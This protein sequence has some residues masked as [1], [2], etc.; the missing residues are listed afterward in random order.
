MSIANAAH[1]SMIFKKSG[2]WMDSYVSDAATHWLDGVHNVNTNEPHNPSATSWT[3]IIG[4]LVFTPRYTNSYAPYFTGGNSMYFRSTSSR[5]SEIWNNGA[6]LFENT[7]AL[8][9]ELVIDARDST[10]YGCIARLNKNG[11]DSVRVNFNRQSSSEYG[12]I[13]PVINTSLT[14]S[15]I[16][17]NNS[18]WTYQN[19]R[20]C[21]LTISSAGVV[22][23]YHNGVNSATFTGV[24]GM[25]ASAA[26]VINCNVIGSI[27]KGYVYRFTTHA[28]D[29]SPQE[30]AKNFNA[31]VARFNLP[32]A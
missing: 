3:D 13:T 10:G 25:V 32:T 30:I 2:G 21:A 16:Y 27:Y 5:S 31:D 11:D 7:T 17:Q 26:S 23:F 12:A 20:Y 1:C 9:V 22:K 8:T 24:A 4:G 6:K 28:R 18:A 14:P 19:T 15:T 29:L